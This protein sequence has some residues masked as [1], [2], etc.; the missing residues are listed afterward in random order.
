[1]V[2]K[3]VGCILLCLIFDDT[4]LCARLLTL[5]KL[6]LDQVGFG[7]FAF[8]SENRP[9][10]VQLLS[11]SLSRRDTNVYFWFLRN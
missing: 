10:L 3:N 1:V 7:D 9:Y 6:L 5:S 8:L 2:F 4:E 11:L